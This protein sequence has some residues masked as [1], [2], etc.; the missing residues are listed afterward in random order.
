M[1]QLSYVKYYQFIILVFIAGILWAT[2]LW[3]VGV[4]PDNGILPPLPRPVDL[5][6]DGTRKRRKGSD[7]RRN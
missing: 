7:L 6:K 3:N 2:G 5:T 4:M 1:Y